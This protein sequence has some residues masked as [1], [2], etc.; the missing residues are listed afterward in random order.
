MD[1]VPAR[2]T[3]CMGH[4]SSPHTGEPALKTCDL[5]SEK[6]LSGVTLNLDMGVIRYSAEKLRTNSNAVEQLRLYQ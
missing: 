1:F 3:G 5:L 6:Y 4:Q 2:S